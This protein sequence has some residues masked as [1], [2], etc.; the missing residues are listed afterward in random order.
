M[1]VLTVIVMFGGIGY[2]ILVLQLV[3]LIFISFIM[4]ARWEY[5]IDWMALHGIN[6]VYAHTAA[7]FIWVLI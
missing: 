5:E 2:E 6:L 3:S 4:K 7:E 1:F